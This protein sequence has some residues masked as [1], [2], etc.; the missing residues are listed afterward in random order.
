[1]H[2]CFTERIF[3]GWL[4]SSSTM[5]T[6]GQANLSASACTWSQKRIEK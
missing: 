2:L 4:G 6:S 5:L 3:Q 1:V